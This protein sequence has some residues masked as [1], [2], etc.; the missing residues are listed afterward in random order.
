MPDL[1][2]RQLDQNLD[3]KGDAVAPRTL[4]IGQQAI[5]PDIVKLDVPFANAK[6]NDQRFVF[7]D[8]LGSTAA[9][10]V[11]DDSAA[12]YETGS[13]WIDV[14]G[15]RAYVCLNATAGAAIWKVLT[16]PVGAVFNTVTKTGTYTPTINDH[17]V[18]CD[19]TGGSFAIT[20]PP[21]GTVTGLILHIKKIDLNGNTV[22]IDG[23]G[24]ETIDKGLTA[25]ITTQF[26]VV[27]IQ[28]DGTEWWII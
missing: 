15:Q 24:S 22:T 9:P 5:N 25:I 10:T 11:T 20:L 4:T 7:K 13:R 3:I 21:A 28:S 1:D 27:S 18:L 16:G 8:N 19:T 12:G 6:V 26:E 17:L 23:D 2:L 14:T